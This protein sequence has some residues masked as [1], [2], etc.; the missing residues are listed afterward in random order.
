M[1]LQISKRSTVT[2]MLCLSLLMSFFSGYT[3]FQT[4]IYIKITLL[5]LL[6]LL[7]LNHG[8]IASSKQSHVFMVYALAIG[9]YIAV[10]YVFISD[11]KNAMYDYIF[12]YSV[13]LL[14]L[15]LY[16]GEDVYERIISGLKIGATIAMWS[17]LISVVFPQLFTVVL[18]RFYTA[19]RIA[20][21]ASEFSRGIYSG[22]LGE[23]AYSAHLLVIGLAIELTD[24]FDS[25]NRTMKYRKLIVVILY[26]GAIM[27]TSKRVLF[28]IALALIMIAFTMSKYSNKIMKMLPII[29]SAILGLVLVLH[30]IPQASVTLDRL[31]ENSDYGSMNGRT[32]YWAVCYTMF[33]LK[34]I[35]GFGLGTYTAFQSKF[36]SAIGFN[37]HNSYIQLLAE[38]GIIGC[39]FFYSLF[40]YGLY[41]SV[42]NVYAYKTQMSYLIL[43]LQLV[44]L[45]YAATGN[46]MHQSTQLI[47]YFFSLAC[48]EFGLYKYNIRFGRYGRCEFVNEL[49]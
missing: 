43:Y 24:M 31:F 47:I 14:F 28:I 29:A 10:Q 41:K 22:Y 39:L 7:F 33:N 9:I 26:L 2:F 25:V 8:I 45:V 49:E 38:T 19:D 35:T 17:V 34:P 21:M 44:S 30:F 36:T 4:T 13:A 27:L 40:A 12:C 37:A 5:S 48:T 16:L 3:I 32:E 23:K 42:R 6:L 11:F 15:L 18:S 46:V 20:S 1:S